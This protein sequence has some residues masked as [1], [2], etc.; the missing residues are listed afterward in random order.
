M[1][2]NVVSIGNEMLF[3]ISKLENR[4][5]RH[6]FPVQGVA[7]AAADAHPV[8]VLV[9]DTYINPARTGIQTL[10]RGVIAGLLQSN[11]DFHLVEWRPEKQGLVRLRPKINAALGRPGE[12]KFLPAKVLLRPGNWRLVRQARARNYRI[13]IH[14]HP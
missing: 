11:A 12:K 5:T 3:P 13:P 14:L 10:V 2:A 4:F 1:S 7:M 6:T 9:T 8:F